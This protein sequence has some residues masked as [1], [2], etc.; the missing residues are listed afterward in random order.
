MKEKYAHFKDNL[1]K[2]ISTY[3]RLML[4]PLD[5]FYIDAILNHFPQGRHLTQPGNLNTNQSIT[6]N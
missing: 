3:W 6:I 2:Y 4:G 1:Q 5:R